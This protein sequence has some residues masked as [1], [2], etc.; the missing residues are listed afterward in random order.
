MTEH[1]ITLT[2]DSIKIL[3]TQ[4][5]TKNHVIF[6]TV[7]TGKLPP[8]RAQEYIAFVAKSISEI[9]S[10][11]KVFGLPKTIDIQITEVE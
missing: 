9:V 8:T 2:E 6:V 4:K 5:L 11:A 10:P 7:D 3:D 1:T